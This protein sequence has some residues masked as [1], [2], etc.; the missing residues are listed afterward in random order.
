V[1]TVCRRGA[2]LIAATAIGCGPDIS[3][4]RLGFYPPR[5]PRCALE[6]VQADPRTLGPGGP[7][8]VVGYVTVDEKHV[9]D[10]YSERY[11]EIVRP[12]ACRMGGEAVTILQAASRESRHGSGT[13][14]TWGVL[15]YRR[16]PGASY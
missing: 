15:R 10:P 16:P 7:W 6:F 2:I 13:G 5:E 14:I 12:R 4:R 9:G 3:E 11:R 8:E 1:S